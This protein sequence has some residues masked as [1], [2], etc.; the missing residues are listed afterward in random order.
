MKQLSKLL[1]ALGFSVFLMMPAYAAN[2]EIDEI[3]SELGCVSIPFT[4]SVK[5]EDIKNKLDAL[6]GD[7]IKVDE[8]W[9][10]AQVKSKIEAAVDAIKAG[11][12]AADE[13]LPDWL[14][15]GDA[16]KQT[17]EDAGEAALK[18][19]TDGVKDYNTKVDE[20][21]EQVSSAL[22]ALID[23]LAP[24]FEISGNYR[25][26]EGQRDPGD[27]G[28]TLNAPVIDVKP[29]TQTRGVSFKVTVS[30]D[31]EILG[32]KIG[33]VSFDVTAN[34]SLSATATPIVK[35]PGGPNPV[36]RPSTLVGGQPALTI[37]V[38]ASAGVGVGLEI[39]AGGSLGFD[40]DFPFV[41]GTL[42]AGKNDGCAPKGPLEGE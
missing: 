22:K 42:V 37:Q 30:L 33:G 13:E 16:L 1:T 25:Y 3:K 17:I 2:P 11:I 31:P 27:P 38:A 24:N 6:I 7:T 8:D 41:Q 18:Q 4:A 29:L 20:K 9:I 15:D 28:W 36:N 23:A 40:V 34:A 35:H 32:N 14:L 5:K 12:E 19:V 10:E 39:N 26:C 21:L